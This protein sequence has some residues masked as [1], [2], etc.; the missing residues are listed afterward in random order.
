MK[1]QR[2]LDTTILA[3]AW[4]ETPL[5]PEVERMLD[6]QL[7]RGDQRLVAQAVGQLEE[8][9]LSLAWRSALNERL[10]ELQPT[11]R[12]PWWAAAWRSVLATGLAASVLS[13][14]LLRA[15]PASPG[16]AESLENELIRI[17]LDS[18][19]ALD[20]AGTGLVPHEVASARPAP[21]EEEL[22]WSAV[23]L[24]LL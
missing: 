14:A 5:T 19:A 22:H 3:A 9:E 15:G 6:A 23:D 8:D 16:H 12:K 11:K 21:I 24:D 10:L 1:N 18:A 13:V 7:V 2:D 20:L 4:D 17:H